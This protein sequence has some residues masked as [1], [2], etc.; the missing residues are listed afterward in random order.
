MAG[1]KKKESGKPGGGAGRRDYVGKSGVY[2]VSGPHPAG[3]APIRGQAEWGQGE[4]GAMGSFDHGGSELSME[5][6]QLVGG[7]TSGAGGEP[8]EESPE[9]KNRE[10]KRQINRA[11]E[12]KKKRS[13]RAA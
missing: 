10:R 2:P 1:T 12:M 3:D 4:R 6:G 5:G 7:L 8:T 11:G 9:I 13:R